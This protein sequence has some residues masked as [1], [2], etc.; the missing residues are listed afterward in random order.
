MGRSDTRLR[1]SARWT[2]AGGDSWARAQRYEPAA[3]RA[4]KDDLGEGLPEHHHR[5]H[6]ISVCLSV[7]LSGAHKSAAS[8]HEH[9]KRIP[10]LKMVFFF[11]LKIN[12]SRLLCNY[13]ALYQDAN[14]KY[15]K[16]MIIYSINQEVTQADYLLSI[17]CVKHMARGPYP[18]RQR[19]HWKALQ[20]L[21]NT[22]HYSRVCRRQC[23]QVRV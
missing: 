8:Q 21:T 11:F 4:Q 14:L 2:N 9:H 13:S 6:P 22:V 17:S 16:M 23:C 5:H 1:V 18:D 19:L 10:S 7:C 12:Y 3:R 20:R 15:Q